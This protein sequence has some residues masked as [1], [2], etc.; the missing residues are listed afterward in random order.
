LDAKNKASDLAVFSER[1]LGKAIKIVDSSSSF[2]PTPIINFRTVAF[3][4]AP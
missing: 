2:T 1:I 4:D 3:S